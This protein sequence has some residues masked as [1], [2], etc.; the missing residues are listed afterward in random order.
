MKKAIIGMGICVGLL[1]LAGCSKNETHASHKNS[2]NTVHV[3]EDFSLT[4]QTSTT[5]TSDKKFK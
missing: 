4:K 5:A 1:S 2:K 3:S